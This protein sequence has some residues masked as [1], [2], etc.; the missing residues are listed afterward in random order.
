MNFTIYL[1]GKFGQEITASVNDYTKSFFKEFVSKANS[2]SQIII[3]RNGDIMNY[4][5]IRKIENNQV[6]G[7]C[8]Q[9][10][11]QYLST[12]DGLFSVFENIVT[13]IAVRGDILYLNKKGNIEA[14][15]SDFL[16]CID[17]TERIKSFCQRE[18]ANLISKCRDLPDINLSSTD[19]DISY[20]KETDNCNEII[21]AAVKNGYTF[22]YKDQD[23]DTL[24]LA[25]Y[26]STLLALNQ[27]NDAYKKR[28]SEQE[29]K[30]KVLEMQKKQMGTVILLIIVL[31][32]GSM[33]FFNKIEE[34]NE[35]IAEKETTIDNQKKE[36]LI[37]TETTNDLQKEKQVLQGVNNDL[38]VK[39]KATSKELESVKQEVETLKKR[40]ETLLKE[41]DASEDNYKTLELNYNNLEVK[42]K[43]TEIEL[44]NKNKSYKYLEENYKKC[45]QRLDLMEKKYYSTK[46]GKKERK[47][48]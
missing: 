11:G 28:I 25:G 10:N 31:F 12:T 17:E 21:E 8:V 36:N 44:A 2:P 42:L 1:F 35:F 38:I 48:K 32:L 46:E 41:I 16:D 4:G 5:Y 27:E 23:Y 6:F 37:L 43:K 39:Q 18:L 19:L 20:F 40:N 9:T 15:I 14:K 34:K 47:L 30:L 7:I 29:K 26:R 24:A 13:D 3:H 22:I 45:T 33:T